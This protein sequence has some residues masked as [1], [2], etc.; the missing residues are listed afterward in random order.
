MADKHRVTR[1]AH[2]GIKLTATIG[3]LV[4]AAATVLVLAL[5]MPN[6]R[7]HPYPG[8]KLNPDKRLGRI[9]E[10]PGAG[11]LLWPT[12]DPHVAEQPPIQGPCGG[13][14][15]P[16]TIRPEDVFE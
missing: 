3:L 9:P 15:R 8:P 7:A 6:L 16:D 11:P 10:T 14:F 12:P 5:G 4:G 2:R 1:S 13:G